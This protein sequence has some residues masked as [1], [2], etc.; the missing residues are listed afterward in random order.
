MW[1]NIL[2]LCAL[3]ITCTLCY[4]SIRTVHAQQGPSISLGQNPIVN[5]Y[6]YESIQTTGTSILS[7]SSGQDFIVTTA[8]VHHRYCTISID[9]TDVY[10]DEYTVGVNIFEESK[11]IDSVFRQ[12]TAHLKIANGSELQLRTSYP[13][14]S[15]GCYYY[16]EGYYAHQ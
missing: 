10:P 8:Y 1:K 3:I 6:G 13:T 4:N 9:G 14:G 2:S 12:G 11:G 7:N 5:L 15:I 16:I